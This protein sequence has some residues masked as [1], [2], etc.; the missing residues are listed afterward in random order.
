MAVH[1]TVGF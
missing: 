1:K